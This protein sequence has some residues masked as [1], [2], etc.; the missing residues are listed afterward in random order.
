MLTELVPRFIYK[1]YLLFGVYNSLIFL[2]LSFIFIINNGLKNFI[3][4]LSNEKKILTIITINALIFFFIPTKTAIISLAI[5]LI[6]LLIIKNFNQKIILTIIFFN[7]LYWM[8]S[9]KFLKFK[10][11]NNNPCGP[12]QAI[13]A[14]FDFKIEQ[15]FFSD[16]K[17]KI[18]NTVKC[19]SEHFKDKKED[20]INSKKL[21]N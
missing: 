8:V 13:S 21:S 18:I 11:I 5:I 12:I 16:K 4:F 19:Y 15:G 10:Y 7:I 6:Y 9:Y 17:I 3:N 1:F 14:K 20:Y 2:Y